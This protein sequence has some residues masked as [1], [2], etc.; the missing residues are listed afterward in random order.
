MANIIYNKLQCFI[1]LF[2]AF[3]YVL[4]DRFAIG[5]AIGAMKT[6]EFVKHKGTIKSIQGEDGDIIDCVDIYQQPA[7]SHPLL[8]NH[9]IQ[10]KPSS[11]PGG[12]KVNSIQEKLFQGWH[13]SGQCPEATI[14][15]RRSQEDEHPPPR[16]IHFKPSRTQL[17]QSFAAY[18]KNHEYAT[19]Y[20]NGDNLYGARSSINIWK[21]TVSDDGEISIAQ[22]WVVAGPDEQLNTMEAGWNVYSD[23]QKTRFFIYWTSDGYHETGCYNLECSG[24]VQTNNEFAIGSSIEAVSSYDS[25]QYDIGIT[26]Y[27][28]NENWWL[29]VEDQLIG[30]WPQSIFTYLASSATTLDWGGEIYNSKPGG[31]HTKTQMGSGHFP[32]EGYGKASYF[33][34]IQYMDSTGNFRDAEDMGLILYVTNPSC[35]NIDV[36][37]DKNYFG[38]GTHVY[39]GGPGYSEDICP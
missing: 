7:F 10:M 39:F 25:N 29:Q 13:K 38:N 30:Y 6:K 9:T 4:S 11:I 35:Y 27:K 8:K 31:S 14:P 28:N 3:Y 2:L 37:N 16:A 33:R 18:H 21:P 17:N 32:D 20:I 5:R 1:V 15:I 12:V 23:D 36:Q 26:I 24:F 34:N 22:I 19:V